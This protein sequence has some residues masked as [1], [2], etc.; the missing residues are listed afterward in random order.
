MT[1]RQNVVI[2][3]GGGAGSAIA[4]SLSSTLDPTKYHLIVITAR[5]YFLHLVGS[6]RAAVTPEGN[7]P[8]QVAISLD[9]LFVNSN[10]KIV[11]G[12][13]TAI[14]DD[15]TSGGYVTLV[16]GEEVPYLILVLAPGR[17]WDGPLAAP[18]TSPEL[19]A[20]FNQWHSRFEK[21]K[22]ILLVGGG[23]VGIGA[24]KQDVAIV[25][26][27]EYLLNDAYPVKYRKDIERH[28]RLRGVEVILGDIVPDKAEV[29]NVITRNGKRLSPDLIVSRLPMPRVLTF[30]IFRT[31]V[32][33]RGPRPNNAF[34]KSS[35][36]SQVLSSNGFVS[37]LP[38]FQIP[39]YGR[40]FAAG[41]IADLEEQK[42]LGKYI[43]HSNIITANIQA[44]VNGQ[45][46]TKT[47]TLSRELIVITIG[48]N[49]GASY[50]GILW[51]LM[52]GNWISSLVKSR[53]LLVSRMRKALGH[54]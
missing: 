47:H 37:V 51:C 12:E 53:N 24:Y 14:S 7:F 52:F 1:S 2:V 43:T 29:G 34:I 38:T 42:Q 18:N 25:H 13:V 5:S 26:G 4:R 54:D 48:K 41:D 35:L 36:G 31:Q 46:T 28:L 30:T 20:W 17:H 19:N 9:K 39:G 27:G 3:G 44:I 22:D 15:G 8:E 50:F 16:S 33:C 32:S 49:G 10:G 6:V 40:I 11:H 23:A 45:Q 21:A